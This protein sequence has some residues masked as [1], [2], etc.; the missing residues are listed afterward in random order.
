MTRR[1]LTGATVWA[2]ATCTPQPAWLLIQDDHVAALGQPGQAPPA[3]DEVLDLAGCHVLPGFVDVHLHL[4]QAAWF[5][6]GGDGSAWRCLADALH[7]VGVAAAAAAEAQAPWLLFWRVARWRWPEGRLPTAQ[8]L[9]AAAPGRRVLVSTLDM[10]RGAVSSAGLVTLGLDGRGRAAFGDDLSC[11]RRGRPTGELW[12][13]AYSLALQHALA[14]TAA[15]ADQAAAAGAAEVLAPEANRCLAYGITHAHD[16]YVAPDWHE[17]LAALDA[18][19]PLRLSWATGSPDGLQ[20]RP[21]GPADAPA[22]PYGQP[23]AGREV[24]LFADGG[25]RCALRLPIR[26]LGSLLGGAI[27]ESWRLH[28]LGPLREARRRR[29]VVHP[30]QRQLHTPY[31]R[32]PDADLEALVAAYA[33]AG[34]RVRIHAL[35]NLAGDQAA[36]VLAR[37]GVPPQAATIDHLLLLDPA[38]AERVAATG[39]A[40][41]YQPGFLPRYGQML[42]AAR[43]DRSMT[44]LGG[45]LLRRAGVPLVLS[46]DYPCGPLDPL[47]NLRAAV[48]RRLPDG[49]TLQ[50]DQ[51]LTPQEAIRAATVD[52]AASLGAPARGGLAP[53]A[54]A[55]L[56]VCDGDPFTPATR[57]TQTWVA[58]TLAWPVSDPPTPTPPP[59]GLPSGRDLPAPGTPRCN[60]RRRCDTRIQGGLPP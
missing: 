18:A 14:A 60:P 31:L 11:D 43:V 48:D 25:D 42:T 3:A 44:V 41:S 12:E 2:G 53:G 30:R 28:G 45:R 19:S 26:A 29:L 22:G 10:H 49:R 50:P 39:A 33:A 8:E 16:P 51:A 52:A 47:H 24:K 54:P 57:V 46:S 17:R 15:H 35:G 20:A 9:D 34:I 40:V 38:T 23:G 21:P 6:T 13:A 55:D 59:S 7:A 56:V 36:R 58:G 27:A 5:P 37:L 4:S 1:L 32:Y